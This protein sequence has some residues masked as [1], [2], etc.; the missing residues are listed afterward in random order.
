MWF[1]MVGVSKMRGKKKAA[2]ED[3]KGG[4]GDVGFPTKAKAK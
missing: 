3:K 2:A 1:E 4:A